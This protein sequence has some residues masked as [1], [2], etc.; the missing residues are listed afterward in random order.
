[1]SLLGAIEVS[2]VVVVAEILGPW[3]C[4]WQ[5]LIEVSKHIDS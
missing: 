2:I 1:M 4:W 3:K 5:V